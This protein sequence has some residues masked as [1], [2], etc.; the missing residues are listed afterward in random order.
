MGE[1]VQNPSF[2]FSKKLK[3][4]NMTERD[5][6]ND[7][8]RA[9]ARTCAATGDINST[10]RDADKEQLLGMMGCYSSDITWKFETLSNDDDRE[11]ATLYA[12]AGDEKIGCFR[13]LTREK[14]SDRIWIEHFH[15]PHG[16]GCF[17]CVNSLPPY[18]DGRECLLCR[19]EDPDPLD[20]HSP[21]GVVDPFCEHCPRLRG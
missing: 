18:H 19:D 10:E 15:G 12:A 11:F 2:C 21:L 13:K 9:F 20:E 5:D 6:D 3:N 1:S 14:G 17:R 7:I 16:K 8:D 4:T